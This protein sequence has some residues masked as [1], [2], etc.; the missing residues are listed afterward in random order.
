MHIYFAMINT[1]LSQKYQSP[2]NNGRQSTTCTIMSTGLII[3]HNQFP[4]MAT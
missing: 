1:D 2:G 4:Y 3:S